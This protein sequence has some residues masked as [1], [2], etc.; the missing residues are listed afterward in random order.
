MRAAPQRRILHIKAIILALSAVSAC[1]LTDDEVG[2]II[3]SDAKD[4]SSCSVIAYIVRVF[5]SPCGVESNWLRRSDT[6]K[7]GSVHTPY[8]AAYI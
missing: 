4:T 3:I 6:A 5:Q 2:G 8:S 1:G 7:A